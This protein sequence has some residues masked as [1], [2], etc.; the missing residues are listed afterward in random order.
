MKYVEC[1]DRSVLQGRVP[2]ANTLFLAGGITGCPDWQSEVAAMLADTD[3]TLVN[4]RRK[5]FPIDDPNAA[6]DQIKWEH[7]HLGQ[8][9]AIL[10][11]FCKDTVQPI[12][13]FE[14]GKYGFMNRFGYVGEPRFKAERSVFVGVEEGYPREVDVLTQIRLDYPQAVIHRTLDEL[15]AS[16][17][18]ENLGN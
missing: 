1:P 3:L 5:N 8:V 10:F 15:A 14:L 12:V 11:W 16:V 6:Y 7:D 17:I 9:D 18:A 4:P 13:L 2:V